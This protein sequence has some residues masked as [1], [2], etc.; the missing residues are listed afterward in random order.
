MLVSPNLMIKVYLHVLKNK[1]KIFNLLIDG[2]KKNK[3][4]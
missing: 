3:D 4:H 2:L 1:A